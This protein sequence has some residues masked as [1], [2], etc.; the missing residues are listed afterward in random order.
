ML[1]EDLA[2]DDFR[3]PNAEEI[4]NAVNRASALTTQLLAFSRRQVA[5]PKTIDVNELVL[6]MD[7]ML[8]RLI[9]EDVELVTALSPDTGKIQADPAQIEQVIMNLV[10]NSRDA[11]PE[12]GRITL[13]TANTKLDEQYARNHLTVR[14][15]DYVMFSVL[16]TGHGMDEETRTH[17]FEPFFTTKEQGK[18]T[19]LGLAQVYGIVKQSGG[20]IA[21]SSTPGQGTSICVYLPRAFGAAM[22][23][24][25]ERP[26]TE[27]GEGTETVLLVEDE[28]EVRRLVSELL[29]Q[30]GYT[31]LAAA[32]PDEALE[33][34][35]F[36]RGPI[37]LLLTDMVMPQMSGREL[38]SRVQWLRPDVRVL[39]MSGYAQDPAAVDIETGIAFLR[40]PF[41]P[42]VLARTIREV[43]ESEIRGLGAAAE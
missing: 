34:C 22:S 13:E 23:D 6:N 30:R 36:H 35:N 33:I 4:L 8:R 1:L 32:Q 7:K 41:T 26:E 14:P 18:G 38:A 42:A 10:V 20:D 15:G 11:M 28:D 12:G 29:Q 40:K 25:R 17:I 19:G 43:L 39:F 21:V 3:R 27:H 2:A 5:Q 37:E 24:L 31:V 9:G 16:D